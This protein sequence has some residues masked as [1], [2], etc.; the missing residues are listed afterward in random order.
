[1][2]TART[3]S[4]ATGFFVGAAAGFGVYVYFG[5]LSMDTRLLDSIHVRAL[6]A[7]LGSAMGACTK[8]HG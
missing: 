7:I 8:G 6:G 4:A 1:M 3:S 5:F 2:T